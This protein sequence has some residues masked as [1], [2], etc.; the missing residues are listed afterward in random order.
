MLDVGCGACAAAAAAAAS[1]AA[2]ALGSMRL[3]FMVVEESML[4]SASGATYCQ[5]LQYTGADSKLGRS[6][7]IPIDASVIVTSSASF[8]GTR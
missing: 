6:I 4:L 2:L 3:G 1:S 7:D 5:L 8:S